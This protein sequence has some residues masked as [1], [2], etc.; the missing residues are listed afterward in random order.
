MWFPSKGDR[1]CP[2]SSRGQAER[3]E[4]IVSWE[5]TMNFWPWA[6]AFLP[7]LRSH[8]CIIFHLGI[9]PYNRVRGG[10]ASEHPNQMLQNGAL[11]LGAFHSCLG[12]IQTCFIGQSSNQWGGPN[13]AEKKVSKPVDETDVRLAKNKIQ[14]LFR[15]YLRS[16]RTGNW[17]CLGSLLSHCDQSYK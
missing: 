4:K 10:Y 3:K 2:G 5:G 14:K 1:A 8:P 11:K 12:P 17:A 6:R 15:E 13:S 7:F 9:Y 16:Q